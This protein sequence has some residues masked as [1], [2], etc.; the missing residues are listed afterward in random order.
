[1]VKKRI[2][3]ID[4]YGVIIKESK[5]YFIPY[6][7][8]H[9]NE[10]E[11][12]R[13]SK[14]FWEDGMFTKA[15]NG[16]M[17]SYEF[18]SLLGYKNPEETMQDYLKNYLTFDNDFLCFAENNYKHYDFVLLSNDIQ[19]WNKYLFGMY[20][21]FKYFRE[22]ITSGGVHMRKPG[23]Q[24]FLYVLDYMGCLPSDCTFIDNSV[25]NLDVAQSIGINTI[26][27][28]RDNET[29]NGNVVNNFQELGQM[30]KKQDNS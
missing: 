16:E 12:A 6:T 8:R 9:F 4:M 2:L 30:L 17:S 26:L 22:I 13:L 1:M 5:G 24:I 7:F 27:F 20:G 15:G 21:L 29:Y 3:L 19:E 10:D 28:N 14:A 18:L 23:K 25:K 11:Y